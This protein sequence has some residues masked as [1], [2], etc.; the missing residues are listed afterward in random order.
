LWISRW[1][2]DF[3]GQGMQAVILKRRMEMILVARRAAEAQKRE[4]SVS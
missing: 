1:E 4:K 2:R 3:S